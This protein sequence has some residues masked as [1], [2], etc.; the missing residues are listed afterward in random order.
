MSNTKECLKNK[1][2]IKFI[3]NFLLYVR[4]ESVPCEIISIID[5]VSGGFV[6]KYQ[7]KRKSSKGRS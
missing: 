7:G 3:S 1:V 4:I 2:P 5:I 6:V